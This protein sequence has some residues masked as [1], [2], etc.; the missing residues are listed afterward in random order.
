MDVVSGLSQMYKAPSGWPTKY[1]IGLAGSV[2]TIELYG[3]PNCLVMIEGGTSSVPM[4]S[5][6]VMSAGLVRVLDN[7]AP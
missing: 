2:K 3:K 6:K 4:L 5:R 1:P 7:G